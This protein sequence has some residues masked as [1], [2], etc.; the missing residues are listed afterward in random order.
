[1]R[2]FYTDNVRVASFYDRTD[3]FAVNFWELSDDCQITVS[4]RRYSVPGRIDTYNFE[5]A[6]Q[7]SGWGSRIRFSSEANES[8]LDAT[9][10]AR[11][12]LN[13]KA[14]VEMIEKAA[15][16]GRAHSL[17]RLIE[18]VGRGTKA[19]EKCEEVFMKRVEKVFGKTK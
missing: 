5:F 6:P 10:M 1:M 18:I 17:N 7:N 15:V 4:I 2:N 8:I 19:H 3:Y 12:D 9:K 14:V 16:Q 13:K 11:R